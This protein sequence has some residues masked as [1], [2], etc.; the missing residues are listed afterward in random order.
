MKLLISGKQLDLTE[1]MKDSVQ[2]ELAFLQDE[3]ENDKTVNVTLSGGKLHQV[4]I[5]LFHNKEV[6]KVEEKGKDMYALIK[7]S[8]KKL[9]QIMKKNKQLER[10]F[11]KERLADVYPSA[12]VEDEETDTTG[13]IVKRKIFDLKPMSEEEAILQMELLGH[14][15][16]IFVNA[17]ENE[18]TCL[19]YT[20]K[21]NSYGVIQAK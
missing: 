13:K 11:K 10:A 20:R 4:S 18:K 14:Q 3:I 19:L 17:D 8:A 5:L 12:M 21:D 16:F 15:Q 2:T 7:K 9:A 6:I 1:G